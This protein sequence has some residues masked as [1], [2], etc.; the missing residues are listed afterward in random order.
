[1]HTMEVIGVNKPFANPY[2][3]KYVLFSAEERH[4]WVNYPFKKE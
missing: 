2:S 4:F 3:S 1:M